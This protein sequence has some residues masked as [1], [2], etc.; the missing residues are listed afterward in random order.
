MTL[1]MILQGK[2]KNAECETWRHLGVPKFSTNVAKRT[3]KTQM[4]EFL[5]DFLFIF[6]R[7]I[8]DFGGPG[9]PCTCLG[10]GLESGVKKNANGTKGLTLLG[11]RFRA[12][13]HFLT[14]DFSFIFGMAADTELWALWR[15]KGAQK[16]VFGKPFQSH[17]QV[18]GESENE[19]PV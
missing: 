13:R 7:K 3:E 9:R 14:F 2:E 16:K 1:P 5:D 19:A 10:Q 18:S 17:F 6:C 4:C 15:R 12:F 11:A 8:D